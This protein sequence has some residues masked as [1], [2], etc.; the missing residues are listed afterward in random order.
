[1]FI[2]FLINTKNCKLHYFWKYNFM[3]YDLINCYLYNTNIMFVVL[4]SIFHKKKK[5]TRN[6]VFFPW[7]YYSF[8]TQCRNA[9][10]DNLCKY[11]F[12][13]CAIAFFS[14]ISETM[15]LVYC[16]HTLNAH[17]SALTLRLLFILQNTH[18]TLLQRYTIFLLRTFLPTSPITSWNIYVY[19]IWMPFTL[20]I[21]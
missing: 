9:Q 10:T 13:F 5:K 18:F 15:Y 19:G 11:I 20:C 4:N 3:F 16:F 8:Y 17:E 12:S 6:Y 14:V 7:Y 2:L 21:I 1:M